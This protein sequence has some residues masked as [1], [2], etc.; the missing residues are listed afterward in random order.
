MITLDRYK[1][2]LIHFFVIPIIVG[3][4]GGFSAILF[5]KL[6]CFSH[7]LLEKITSSFGVP[8]HYVYPIVIPVVFLFTYYL[9]KT[10][11]VSP[12]DVTIDEVA[13][14]ISLKKG[15]FDLKK[16]LV[17]LGA[18]SFNIGVGV[19]V[20]REGPIAKLGGVTSELLIK[21]IKI[22][23]LHLPIYLTCGVSSAIS[24]TFNAPIAA[25]L[26]GIEIVLG[27]INSY[28][29]IPLVVSSSVAAIV[30][31]E[32]FGD[33]AAFTVPRLSFSDTEILFLPIAVTL[34]SL[35]PLFFWILFD[36]FSHL[37]YAF[38]HNWE[39]FVF[40]YGTI[41][42]VILF[43]FPEAAGV[44]YE[45][46]TKLL[47]GQ[48]PSFLSFQIFLAKFFAVTL[49]FGAG[50]FGGLM[51]PSIFLGAFGGFSIGELFKLIDPTVNPAVFALIGSASVLSGISKAPF[52]S[53]LIIIELTHSY[54][55]VVPILLASIMTK[56]LLN[57]EC[58]ISF[59][60]RALLNKGIDVENILTVKKAKDFKITQFLK[61]IPPLY[62]N[63][64]IS[65]AQNRL[66]KE[67]WR[68]LP[69]VKSPHNNQLSGIV[70]LR[71]LRIISL[72]KDKN[73]KIKDIMTPE[74]FA[75]PIK[76]SF[77]DILKAL[78]LLETNLI[79]VVDEKENY[80][81]MFDVDEFLRFLSF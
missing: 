63:T 53:S 64:H 43:F 37:R 57:L 31:Q 80:V 34:L 67:K 17:V 24:A 62:E 28:I 35:I 16:G 33:F 65:V 72:L 76:S 30:S 55:L 54:Q 74:P 14:R 9:S 81:G 25:I 73:L 10:F 45:E 18:T 40:V 52:R 36:F 60:K 19:P 42:G 6:I 5:R 27:K 59:L 71:D 11:S 23:R 12:E 51:S 29:L 21:I 49:A 1:K 47:N 50:I 20:G 3:I 26:F 22:D 68:Y 61:F 46:I 70:S 7:T 66:L 56:Y 41:V 48:I 69:V 78:A 77:E 13:K 4:L 38:R 75:L 39:K 8:L 58:E 2:Q 15:G 32:A 44:G 79:P